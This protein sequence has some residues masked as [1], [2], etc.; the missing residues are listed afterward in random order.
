[1]D[2]KPTP[3]LS[4]LIITLNE[5]NQ[6]KPLLVDLDFADEIIIVD[7]FSTDKTEAICKSFEKV[8]FIQ[9]KF[10]NYSSQRNFAILHAKNDWILFLDADERLTPALK[11]EIITTI[12]TNETFSAFLFYRTF[13]FEGKV[14]HFSGNQNDKIF[15]LFNKNQAEYTTDRLVH[16]KLKVNGKIGV[17]KNKLI[18]YSYANFQAYKSKTIRYGEFKAQEKFLKKQKPSVLLHFLHPAYNFLFNYII[19]LGFLDGKKGLIICYLNANSIHIRYQELEQLW[20]RQQQ[21]S[22]KQ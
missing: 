12:K 19:R 8:T 13:M 1:M 5:E 2:S 7:S 18:H 11:N 17:L 9:N 20:K 10:E 14:L 3:N 15:R 4:V 22:P 16:E 6:I 21:L